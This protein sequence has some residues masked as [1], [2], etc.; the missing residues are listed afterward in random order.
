MKKILKWRAPFDIEDGNEF[1]CALNT[2]IMRL[3]PEEGAM[4]LRV[5]ELSHHERIF[6]AVDIFDSEAFNEGVEHFFFYNCGDLYEYVIEGLDT[7]GMPGLALRLQE[8]V[9]AIF[10]TEIPLATTSRQDTLLADE[11]AAEDAADGFGGYYGA[12]MKL[13][14]CLIAWARSNRKHFRCGVDQQQSP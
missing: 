3:L 2:A 1:R 9:I 10:G 14:E 6:L 13:S 11:E 8:Y 4:R 12:S 5:S 7:I